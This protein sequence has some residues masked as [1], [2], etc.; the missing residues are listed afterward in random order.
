MPRCAEHEIRAHAHLGYAV[1]MSGSERGMVIEEALN[2]ACPA[3]VRA[4]R[5]GGVPAQRHAGKAR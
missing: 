3:A 4:L 1:Y 2:C 5:K